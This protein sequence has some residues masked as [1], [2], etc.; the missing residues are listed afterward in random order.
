MMVEEQKCEDCTIDEIVDTEE[1][2]VATSTILDGSAL[3]PV[4]QVFSFVTEHI[5]KTIADHLGASSILD[6]NF[7]F[8]EQ[9]KSRKRFESITEYTFLHP[10]VGQSENQH[11]PIVAIEPYTHCKDELGNLVEKPCYSVFEFTPEIE[12]ENIQHG[13]LAFHEF[14]E[15]EMRRKSIGPSQ[16]TF[17]HILAFFIESRTNGFITFS[18]C[19]KIENQPQ[20]RW[21]F[22][23]SG[24]I[25]F[26]YKLTHNPPHEVIEKSFKSPWISS[27]KVYFMRTLA[28]FGA[29]TF[30]DADIEEIKNDPDVRNVMKQE[31]V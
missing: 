27:T 3:I 5:A 8:F 6:R 4:R 30:S 16:I 23:L 29:F 19:E 11:I 1:P 24:P 25:L 22:Q 18:T 15:K 28:P 31:T 10:L 20:P 21:V 2:K 17:A 12:K 26:I 14:Y 7:T 13:L 9:L